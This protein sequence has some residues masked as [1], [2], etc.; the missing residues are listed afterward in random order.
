MEEI[1]FKPSDVSIHP[2]PLC[3]TMGHCEAEVAAAMTV[4]ACEVHGNEWR[5]VS[6]EEIIYSMAVDLEMERAPFA[7]I[8][9]NPFLRPDLSDL[10]KRGFA[11]WVGEGEIHIQFTD[12]GLEALKRWVKPTSKSQSSP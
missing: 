7:S 6:R 3:G 1:T 9:R 8:L 2:I 12:K 10:V 11:V 4:R 5:A